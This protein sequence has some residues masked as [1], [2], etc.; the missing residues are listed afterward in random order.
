MIDEGDL[1]WPSVPE[2][3]RGYCEG[4]A[5]A[6]RAE[7]VRIVAAEA[8]FWHPEFWYAGT[9]DRVVLVLRNGKL[10]VRELKT[11]DASDV[12]CQVA[13]YVHARNRWFPHGL[14]DDRVG[15]CLR[16]NANGTFNLWDLDLG[17]GWRGFSACLVL[18]ER[19]RRTG[20]V[21]AE[22]A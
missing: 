18:E 11:G 4:Y 14:V 21:L 13:A 3:W 1:H 17:D 8:R 16:V 2:E 19:L 10:R 7:S 22:A 15:E 20:R 9:L 5:A 6:R 12:E